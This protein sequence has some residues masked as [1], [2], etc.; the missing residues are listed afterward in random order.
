M[1]RF[2]KKLGYIL[3]ASMLLL[4]SCGDKKEN[5][6]NA[7]KNS[8]GQITASSTSEPAGE[9]YLKYKD[10]SAEDIVASL[11]LEQKASGYKC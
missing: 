2:K 1:K 7:G 6:D 9:K 3:V 8:S 10:M 4:S 5:A 11:T